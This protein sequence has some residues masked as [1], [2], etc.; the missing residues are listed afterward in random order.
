MSDPT[1]ASLIDLARKG[2]RAAFGKLVRMHQ[3]RVMGCAMKMLG[4]PAEADDATQETFVRA[5]RAL[6][7]FDGRSALSTW[8]YRICVNVSLNAIRSRRRRRTESLDD[9]HGDGESI[10]VTVEGGDPLQEAEGS[11]LRRRVDRALE[12]LSETLRT[13]VVLVLMQGLS[14]KDAAEVLGTTEGTVAWRIH[15]ARRRLRGALASDDEPEVA[16]SPTVQTSAE[17]SHP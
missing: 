5:W 15:E 3:R 13:T 9:V 8:L 10:D 16:A 6:A 7:A 2:D 1:E 4:S 11:E 17:R 14:H 12:G